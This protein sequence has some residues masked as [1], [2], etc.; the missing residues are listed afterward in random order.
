[1]SETGE[2]TGDRTGLDLSEG[3]L[4]LAVAATIPVVMGLALKLDESTMN[5]A[6]ARAI[7]FVL[8]A[9]AGDP[10]AQGFVLDCMERLH[11]GVCTVLTQSAAVTA[12]PN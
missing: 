1:M 6:A 7:C 3:E 11:E 8:E 4:A 5:A 12:R 2:P 9:R 10:D